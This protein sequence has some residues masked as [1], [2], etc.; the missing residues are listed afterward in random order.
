MGSGEHLDQGHARNAQG[1][2]GLGQEPVE[3]G[4]QG[5]VARKAVVSGDS[6]TAV[7]LCEDMST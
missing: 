3:L 7:Q 4:L 2:D 6:L 5:K 1:L